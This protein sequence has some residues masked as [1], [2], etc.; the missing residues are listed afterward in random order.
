[1]SYFHGIIAVQDNDGTM[2]AQRGGDTCKDLFGKLEGFR[3]CCHRK[4]GS[5]HIRNAEE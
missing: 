4:P 2:A 1:M 3:L 5:I